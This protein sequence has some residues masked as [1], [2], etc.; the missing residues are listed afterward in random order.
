MFTILESIK[1]KISEW[2]EANE[3][4]KERGWRIGCLEKNSLMIYSIKIEYRPRRKET[5]LVD[6][7]ITKKP[8]C[9]FCSALQ[10]STEMLYNVN[11]LARHCML[12]SFRTDKIPLRKMKRKKKNSYNQ[13]QK[14]IN[15]S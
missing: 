2:T 6:Y 7:F 5:F 14:K 3:I 1:K 10:K 8:F 12:Y 9:P 15:S 13:I 11:P 4:L